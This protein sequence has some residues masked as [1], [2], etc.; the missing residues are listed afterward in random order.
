MLK[1]GNCFVR[2]PVGR[3]IRVKSSLH[4]VSL[5]A[6]CSYPSRGNNSSHLLTD[7]TRA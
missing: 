2:V 6:F 4:C 1:I 3:A 5:R 7:R